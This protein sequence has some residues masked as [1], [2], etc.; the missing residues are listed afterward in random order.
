MRVFAPIVP[1]PLRHL[2]GLT[3]RIA[4]TALAMAALAA[5]N[6]NPNVS[7]CS[8]TIAPSSISVPVNGAVNVSASAFDCDGNSI[9]NKTINYQSANTAV[10]TVTTTG[11]VIGISVGQTSVSAV[12]NGKSGTAQVTVTPEVANTVTVSPATFTLR[13]TNVK[14]FSATAKN[15][16]GTVI[17]G[18]TFRWSSS[19][20]SIASVD[21]SGSVTALTPGNVVIAAD[22]DGVIGNASLTVTNIPI[23]ACSLAPASQTVTVTNQAQPVITLRDTANNALPTLGRPLAWSSDNEIVATVSTSGVITAR[24]SGTARITASSVEYP[25]VSCG[26]N[27]IAVDPRI[28]TA[29]IQPRTGSLR[30]GIPRQLTVALADSVGGAIPPGRVITWT[31]ATPAIASVSATG[32]V[33][34]LS[35]GTARIAVNAEGARDTVNFSVT[36]IPV[37]TVRLTPLSSSIVQGQT[38][39]LSATVEDSTGAVVTDRFIEWSS[40]DP[41]KANVSQTGLVSSFSP[42]TVT[43]SAISETRT[44]TANVTVQQ[45]PVDTIAVLG[46]YSV[47][48]GTVTKAFAITLKDASGNQLFGRT[49]SITS[50]APG[51]ATGAVNQNATQVTVTAF[52]TGTTT[53]T[54]RALNPNGQ[55]E[56]KATQVLVTILP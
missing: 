21:Q 20:S 35:L 52:A 31:S 49:V 27:F 9:R 37:A 18:R 33:T 8:V 50:S 55:P 54:L 29:T 51:V 24:K 15:A 34:G 48:I 5:C 32:L 6:L 2:A 23:G 53:F 41:T 14:T 36:K 17:T 30:I 42:G 56:G 39:Q 45:V 10:A 12:A 46:D 43:I 19:N 7:A 25:N 16:T 1:A 44:G 22:A 40:N 3:P 13:L 38:V 26:T 4:V 11:Q 47:T 28:A